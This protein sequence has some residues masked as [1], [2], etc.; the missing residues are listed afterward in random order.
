MYHLVDD[1]V[2]DP[3]A[4]LAGWAIDKGIV[5]IEL[6]RAHAGREYPVQFL[7][8]ADEART[9]LP[10]VQILLHLELLERDL[11]LNPMNQDVGVA[12][13][14]RVEHLKMVV[15]PACDITR[16]G[17]RAEESG[18]ALDWLLYIGEVEHSAGRGVEFEL[19]KTR[20][21]AAQVEDQP[22]HAAGRD[23]HVERQ[24]IGL[25][26]AGEGQGAGRLDALDRAVDRYVYRFGEGLDLECRRSL[27]RTA[28]P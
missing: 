17:M 28:E 25:C 3:G 8:G 23:I 2:A 16:S 4:L 15:F 27:D 9:V 5:R 11:A 19:D 1:R 24:A 26:G 12:E 22:C 14:V 6:H 13:A 21:D 18:W 20:D 10:G 7:V